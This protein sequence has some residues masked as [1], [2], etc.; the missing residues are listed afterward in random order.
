MARFEKNSR[1]KYTL[2]ILLLLMEKMFM[3]LCRTLI[4]IISIK[5]FCC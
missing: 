4:C 2:L 5:Y 3:S 1:G